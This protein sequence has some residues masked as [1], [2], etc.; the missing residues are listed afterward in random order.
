MGGFACP[1]TPHARPYA[2][3]LILASGPHPFQV[4]SGPIVAPNHIA[5]APACDR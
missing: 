1:W 5:D 3:P 4:E 2:I